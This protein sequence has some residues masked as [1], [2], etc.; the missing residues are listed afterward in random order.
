VT[1]WSALILSLGGLVVFHNAAAAT[2]L[3]VREGKLAAC[4]STPNCVSSQAT[5]AEHAIAPYGY[6]AALPDAKARLKRV[7]GALPRTRLVGETE[8]YLH[9]EFTSRIFRFVDDVEFYFDDAAKLIH[10]RSASRLG[11]SDFGVNRK[12]VE[13]IRRAFDEAGAR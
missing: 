2:S 9:F 4:P 8:S 5:D 7:V 6:G 1:K 12:R 13:A 3:G 10:M 11:R